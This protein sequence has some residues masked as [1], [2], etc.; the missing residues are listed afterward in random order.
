LVVWPKATLG[1]V[2]TM[3]AASKK[4]LRKILS[5]CVGLGLD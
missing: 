3:T 1:A 4:E 5:S 2:A